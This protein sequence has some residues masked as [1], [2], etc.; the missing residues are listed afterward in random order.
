MAEAI[1]NIQ[2]V[3]GA[4]ESAVT[5][6]DRLVLDTTMPNE[7]INAIA[8]DLRAIAGGLKSAKVRCAVYKTT[9]AQASLALT[10]TQTA[11]AVDEY[12]DIA[13]PSGEKVR[14]TAKSTESIP[15]L[16]FARITSDTAVASSLKAVINGNS[17]LNTRI[18]ADSSAGVL[19]ITAKEPGTVGNNIVVIDGTVNGMSPAGGNLAGGL[20]ASQRTTGTMTLTFAN[21]TANDTISIGNLTFTYKASAVTES[22]ITIGADL[23]AV[24][25]NTAAKINAHS[26]LA[27]WVSAS[28]NTSTG[29]VT[30][31]FLGDPRATAQI[32]FATSDATMVSFS[33]PSVGTGVTLTND[34]TTT[35]YGIGAP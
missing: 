30:V 13:F 2:I 29:V 17:R 12:I 9:E 26:S 35:A 34:S 32:K 33:Q 15:D 27:G 6:G 23:A 20:D 24:T 8:D 16:Q 21:I 4:G 18:S 25:T 7:A 1:A 10:L 31:T 3:Y 28:G 22:E 11:I 14:L 5:V 19:T